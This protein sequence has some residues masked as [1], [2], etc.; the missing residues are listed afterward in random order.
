MKN[1]ILLI[2]IITFCFTSCRKD[3]QPEPKTY[4]QATALQSVKDYAIFKKGTYWVYQDSTSLELDSVWVYKYE[5][6]VDSFPVTAN[7]IVVCPVFL[8]STFSSK[9]RTNI[10]YEY[11]TAYYVNNNIS[12]VYLSVIDSANGYVGAAIFIGAPFIL[13]K[14]LGFYL[15][16]DMINLNAIQN[17]Y[18]LR[19]GFI[20]NGVLKYHHTKDWTSYYMDPLT[21]F[22]HSHQT[23]QYIAPNI[24]LVRKEVIDSNQV[25]NLIRYNIVQ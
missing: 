10:K 5:E 13:G 19:N 21:Y 12:P 17:N 3:K 11:N 2:S 20:K 1:F 23:Y 6:T 25:W 14:D 22:L 4:G 24:G 18:I 7:S 16:D 9:F 8:Y 15:S